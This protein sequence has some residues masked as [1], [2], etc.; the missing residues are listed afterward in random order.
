[1]KKI[2]YWFHWVVTRTLYRVGHVMS[3][4]YNAAYN[5]RIK[6][7]WD[8]EV[9]ST[10]RFWMKVDDILYYCYCK[11]MCASDV[12]DKYGVGWIHH[13]Y[14]FQVVIRL[15]HPSSDPSIFVDD[16]Y[17]HDLNDVLVG[18]D[19]QGFVS[20]D[21]SRTARTKTEAVNTIILQATDAIP[22]SVV[23]H[24]SEIEIEKVKPPYE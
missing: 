19:K 17:K 3:M 18:I 11:P 21:V 23:D 7:G 22:G 12:W 1:M 8:T 15:P 6:F 20:L 24:V 9:D 14:H 4:I 13:I 16:L 2:D 10:S 5:I